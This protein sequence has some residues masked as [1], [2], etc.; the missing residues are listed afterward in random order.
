MARCK[1]CGRTLIGDE[2]A[3]NRRMISRTLT[4]YLCKDCLAREW[5]CEV[6]VIEERIEY[7]RKNGCMLFAKP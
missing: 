2:I 6:S 5:N 1:A 3:V 4:E 7:F